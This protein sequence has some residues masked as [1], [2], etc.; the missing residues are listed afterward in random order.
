MQKNIVFLSHAGGTPLLTAHTRSVRSVG[1]IK[2]FRHP[3]IPHGISQY[4]TSPPNFEKYGIMERSSSKIRRNQNEYETTNGTDGGEISEMRRYQYGNLD[5]R[6]EAFSTERIF[7]RRQRMYPRS[8]EPLL[9]RLV[10]RQE[11]QIGP[12]Q[13]QPRRGLQVAHEEARRRGMDVVSL[14]WTTAAG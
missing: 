13:G 5:A 1:A 8:R 11:E 12:V 7:E 2:W 10:H 9:G 14:L 4:C 3:E 6:Q